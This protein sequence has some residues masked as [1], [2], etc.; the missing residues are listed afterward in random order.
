MLIYHIAYGHLGPLG[1]T[2]GSFE[3]RLPKNT[4]HGCQVPGTNHLHIAM[5]DR[6]YSI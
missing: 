1:Q 3:L 2:G 5:A 6:T 4:Q